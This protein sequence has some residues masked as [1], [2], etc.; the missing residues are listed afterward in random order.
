M[1]IDKQAF[2]RSVRDAGVVGE[3]GAGFPAHVKYD[4]QVDT[5]IANGCECEPLL[6][7]DQHIMRRHAAAIVAALKTVMEA[8]GA[9]RGIVA[10]KRKYSDIASRMETAVAG[11]GIELAQ[12]DNFY[13]AGDEH[14]L[15]HELLGCAIP[16]LGLPKD[17]GAVV[18]NVGTLYAVSRAMNGQ[19]V[20]HRVVTVTGEV[21][22]PSVLTVPVG[23]AASECIEACGGAAVSDP[24]Y[25]LG[26]PMM[27]RFV[28]DPEQMRQAV[29]TKTGG[30]LIV[31]PRGH[32]LHRMATLSVREMQ[33]QAAAACI[34]CRYCS[35]LC[36]RHNIGHGFET[37][38][39]MRAFGGGV[40]TAMGV[41]QAFMC[42]E[43]GVCELFACPMRLSPRR[44]N[45]MFKAKFREEGLK[46][47]GPREIVD[48]QSIL[49]SFRKVPVSRLA[50]KLDLLKYMDLHPEDG[51]ELAPGSV[52]IPL[53]QHAGAP[54]VAR[55]RPGA[56]VQVGDVIGD[57]PEG[58]LGARVHA[59]LKGTV[60]D[61]GSAITIKG[62]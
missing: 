21:V 6:L 48:S 39:V 52:R 46:Y 32:Y 27:G 33:K 8:M 18:S 40:D 43:C 25:L 54:A 16:P 41:L 53:Q 55:V 50:I 7:T 31:L 28:D 3:G 37:H 2:I 13:P 44:I 49:N 42:S 30:G 29:I 47:D 36:P 35:D 56:A 15:V 14:V 57:I 60:T 61:V 62:D 24:V 12:L 34:Q 58:E 11:T 22:R 59:S 4:A 1:G 9:G 38:R 20:T 26:G 5:V 10:I 45:A 17:V 51:G 19:P 23:A